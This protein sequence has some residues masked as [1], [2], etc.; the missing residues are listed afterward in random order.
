[1]Q[2]KIANKLKCFGIFGIKP[3]NVLKV[4]LIMTKIKFCEGLTLEYFQKRLTGET[5]DV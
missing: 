4:S 2:S 5:S 3:L 1:M